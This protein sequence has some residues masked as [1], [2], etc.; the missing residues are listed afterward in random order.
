MFMMV[1]PNVG[2]KVF[3]RPDGRGIRIAR[4][5]LDGHAKK[6]LPQKFVMG[7][8]F[9]RSVLEEPFGVPVDCAIQVEGNGGQVR[10][11][12]MEPP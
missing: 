2:E 7:G 5:T 8:V 11:A 4:R 6:E 10:A 9:R 3:E 1:L 12:R